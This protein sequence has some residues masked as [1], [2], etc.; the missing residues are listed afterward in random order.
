M[1][2]T[3]Y[4][5]TFFYVIRNVDFYAQKLMR[6]NI[7]SGTK[8]KLVAFLLTN[9]HPRNFSQ[10]TFYVNNFSQIKSLAIKRRVLFSIC[11]RSSSVLDFF[12]VG[13]HK[14]EQFHH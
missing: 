4:D 12:S 8:S 7:F 3:F 5:C 9:M 11:Y 14:S 2:R 6:V 1:T 10:N 13:H